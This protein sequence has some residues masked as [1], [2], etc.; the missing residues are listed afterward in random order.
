VRALLAILVILT[1]IAPRPPAIETLTSTA[2]LPAHLAGTIS[3]ITA[4]EQTADGRY[5]VFDRRAH[6]VYTVPPARDHVRKLIEIGA[7]PGRVLRP[8]AFD[9]ASDE[10]FVVADAPFETG[11]VQIF[12]STGASLGGF[13]L[14]GREVPLIVMDGMVLSG[15]GSLEYTGRSMLMSQPHTG[16]LVVEFGLDG[17]TLRTFGALRATGQEQDR[18]VHLA[19]NAGLVVINPRGG[20][21]YVFLAGVPQFRKYDAAGRLIFE[22]HI[23]GIELD[24]YVQKIPTTW[25]RRKDAAGREIPLIR[26]AVRAAA[27][28]PDG[29]LWVSLASPVT[30]IYDADGDKRRVVQFRAAGIISPSSLTFTNKGQPLVSPG[31]FTF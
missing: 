4:C 13:T 28:D 31:C 22:R 6:A 17:R 27:V 3:E 25:P 29:N 12:H 9:V 18:E 10:T 21:Y 15:I 7:E 5:F 26:P 24:E 20:Y 30:Y 2:A 23:E 8:T 14:A 11:R 16:S 19:L 1:A